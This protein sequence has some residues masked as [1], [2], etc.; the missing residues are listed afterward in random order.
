MAHHI[1][2]RFYSPHTYCN[3]HKRYFLLKNTLYFMCVQASSVYNLLMV[4]LLSLNLHC[5]LHFQFLPIFIFR[6][7]AICSLSCSYLCVKILLSAGVVRSI[8]ESSRVFSTGSMTSHFH[9]THTFCGR[10]PRG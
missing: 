7:S 1:I 8:S 2:P 10:K 6:R 5:L 4:K 9:D 3:T